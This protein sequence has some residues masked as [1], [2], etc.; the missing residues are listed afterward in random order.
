MKFRAH[1]SAQEINELNI[2]K[3]CILFQEKEKN[4]GKVFDQ[5]PLEKYTAL[6]GTGSKGIREIKIIF[7]IQLRIESF[8][9]AI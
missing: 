2:Y 8:F 4:C 1:S 5:F 6:S 9:F 7:C 3:L